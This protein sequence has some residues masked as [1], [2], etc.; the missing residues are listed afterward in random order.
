MKPMDF[1]AC[2]KSSAIDLTVKFRDSMSED[3]RPYRV[4]LCKKRFS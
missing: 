3:A 1:Y 4:K 2:S